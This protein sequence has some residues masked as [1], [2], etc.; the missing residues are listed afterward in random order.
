MQRPSQAITGWPRT[1]KR[2]VD[3]LIATLVLIFCAPLMLLIGLAI[4]LTSLGP[5]I[6]VQQRQG[7]CGNVFSIHKFRSMYHTPPNPPSFHTV[8][9]DNSGLTPIGGFLRR[10]YLD[11]VPQFFDVLFGSMSIVGPR[12]HTIEEAA[13][14]E[15]HVPTYQ[16]RTVAIP[17][18]TGWAQIKNW[19]KSMD[20]IEEMQLCVQYDLEYI[21]SYTLSFD[22]YIIALT[23][24]KMLLLNTFGNGSQR[25]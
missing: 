4:W 14:Y 1:A 9:E 20:S 15:A 5:I 6:Y 18:I 13:Y 22:L 3:I 16:L 21:N 19:N 11:E 24:C 10:R 17:G 25:G 8:T 7:Y 23:T 2:T 12:P